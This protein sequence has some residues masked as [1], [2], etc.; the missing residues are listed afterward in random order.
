M[1]K[2]GAEHKETLPVLWKMTALMELCPPDVQDMVRQNVDGVSEDYDKLKQRILAWA[3]N[4]VANSVG[5]VPMDV[6]LVFN[7]KK[8]ERVEQEDVGA[9]TM[10]TVCHG[11]GGCGHL[12][13]ECPTL[14]RN[15]K[16][17]RNCG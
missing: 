1:G 4:K 11:C 10:N 17:N 13:W 6:G 5:L 7:Q 9:V 14:Q 3:A 8:D 12:Q 2:D 15:E 16:A